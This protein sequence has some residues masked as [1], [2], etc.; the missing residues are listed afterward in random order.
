M[1]AMIK[2][3]LR[4]FLGVKNIKLILSARRFIRSFTVSVSK[5]E[6]KYLQEIKAS[7]PS[8]MSTKDT[9]KFIVQNNATIC[10]YGDA[11]FDI[12]NY[13]NEDDPYQKPSAELTA[14]LSEI[15]KST[16]TEDLLICIPPFNSK[17][18]NIKNYHG[19]LSFWEWYWLTRYE[20]VQALFSQKEFGNSFVTRESV[21][22]EN[23]LEDVKKI[24]EGRDVVFVYGKGG[25]FKANSVIF[26]NIASYKE[27]LIEPVNA[28]SDYSSIFGVCRE[29]DKGVLFII[30]A[31]PTAAVLS[32][33]LWAEGY[34]ALD[35]GHLPNAY[36]EFLGEIISPENIP[37]VNG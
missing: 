22:Y 14:R 37:L 36:D 6:L 19:S 13:K 24:W 23:M 29:F 1:L 4:S 9:I 35:A 21:F 20:E 30:A 28:F 8:V 7:F 34:Q 32:Y 2:N 33:D 5:A 12:C 27:V 16:A 26:D 25:R 15:I 31:G 3:K 10:R 18:N 11:E 17:T